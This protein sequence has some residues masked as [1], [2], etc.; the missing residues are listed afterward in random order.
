MITAKSARN[1]QPRQGPICLQTPGPQEWM[2]LPALPL[3]V[4]SY[5]PGVR[6]LPH[7]VGVLAG[8]GGVVA[9]RGGWSAERQDGTREACCRSTCCGWNART[10][11]QCHRAQISY[12]WPLEVA[13]GWDSCA[14]PTL[15]YANTMKVTDD[16]SDSDPAGPPTGGQGHCTALFSSS[17][18]SHLT[19]LYLGVS[20]CHQ[21]PWS[22]GSVSSL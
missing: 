6:R 4:S 17:W 21:V 19:L 1:H 13:F 15:A 9:E 22:S 8:P 18:K 16:A 20:Q 2:Q 3:M 11:T 5:L 7:C 14:S 10:G 12:L